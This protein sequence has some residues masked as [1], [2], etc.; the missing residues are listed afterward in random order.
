[1]FSM[2]PVEEITKLVI[3][4]ALQTHI[5][6]PRSTQSSVNHC[7]YIDKSITKVEER[8]CEMMDSYHHL[9]Q[10]LCHERMKTTL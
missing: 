3:T 1:M 10:N 7:R 5:L 9:D 4:V 2:D 8:G 6:T